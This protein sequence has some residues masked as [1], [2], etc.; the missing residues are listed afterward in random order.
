[1]NASISCHQLTLNCINEE[2]GR[3]RATNRA[4]SELACRSGSPVVD[5][6]AREA[7][8]R[9]PTV[10]CVVCAAQRGR[11]SGQAGRLSL[12]PQSHRYAHSLMRTACY[13]RDHDVEASS[14][15]AT[16][17][18]FTLT[19][20]HFRSGHPLKSGWRLGFACEDTEASAEIS[21]C[22]PCWPQFL[23]LGL[24]RLRG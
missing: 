15:D 2:R 12:D 1:M 18:S 8:I 16:W 5:V 21:A 13:S 10:S 6:S 14:Q 4:W 3:G 22:D 19:E 23:H 7:S 9:L 24:A 20:I 11:I 17:R